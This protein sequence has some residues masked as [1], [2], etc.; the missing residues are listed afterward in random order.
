MFSNPVFRMVLTCVVVLR[1]MGLKA[2]VEPLERDT[3]A[4]IR[5][6]DAENYMRH[7][8]SLELHRADS[9][10]SWFSGTPSKCWSGRGE[11]GRFVVQGEVIRLFRDNGQVFRTYRLSRKC[12]LPLPD[13]CTYHERLRRSS[14]FGGSLRRSRVISHW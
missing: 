1:A 3:I 10:Y 11:D 4:F 5:S 9:S 6:K 12:V 2:Q 8:Q 14:L 13:A 7:R